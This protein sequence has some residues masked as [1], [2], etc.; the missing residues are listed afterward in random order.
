MSLYVGIDVSKDSLDVC[1]DPAR[2]VARRPNT[3]S[4]AESLALELQQATLVVI[5]ATGGYEQTIV[6]A[7]RKHKVTV[8]VVNPK[9]IRDYARSTGRLAKTDT[10][11]A[12]LLAEYGQVI[13]PAPSCALPDEVVRLKVLSA[14]RDDLLKT[15]TAYINRLKRS[16]DSFVQQGIHTMLETLKRQLD[17]VEQEIQ[18][19]IEQ[20]AVL[21]EKAQVLTQVKGVGPALSRVLLSH[22]PELGTLSQKKVAAL[23]GVAPFNCDSGLFRGK[24]RIWGGRKAIRPVLYMAANIARR[25]DSMMAAFYQRLI[26]AGKP[27]KVALTAC[28]RKLL[29]ILNAKMRDHL[30]TLPS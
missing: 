15:R 3:P 22:L 19:R 1:L 29:V 9:R 6:Q 2:P 28:M 5:E 18:T 27:F 24:R 25:F 8:S 30:A 14:Y 13:Q 4:A 26:D 17:Q 11:D 16:S 23:V 10:L 20:S 21:R 7:L 12:R